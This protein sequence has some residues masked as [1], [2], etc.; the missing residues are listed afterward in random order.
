[1]LPSAFF[2][3]WTKA[4]AFF[5]VTKVVMNDSE[6]I[7]R[8]HWLAFSIQMFCGLKQ[9]MIIGLFARTKALFSWKVS[10]VIVVFYIVKKI[11]GRFVWIRLTWHNLA[12]SQ[13]ICQHMFILIFRLIDQCI[14]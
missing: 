6:D 12:D 4:V 14:V 9:W 10:N 8:C 2:T 3:L 1:M 11:F 7:I 5:G 13:A